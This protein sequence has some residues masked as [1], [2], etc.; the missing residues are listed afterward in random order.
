M[1]FYRDEKI[2]V[3]ELEVK[4]KGKYITSPVHYL[5]I[6]NMSE[7]QSREAWKQK[8]QDRQNFKLVKKEYEIQRTEFNSGQL[9]KLFQEVEKRDLNIYE[10]IL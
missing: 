9:I 6:K 4:S 5:E 3:H 8:R 7:R 10:E 1:I 2:A